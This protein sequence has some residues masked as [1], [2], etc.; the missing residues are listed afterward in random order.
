MYQDLNTSDNFEIF[1]TDND[2]AIYSITIT[3]DHELTN[4]V[5]SDTLGNFDTQTLLAGNHDLIIYKDEVYL[6]KKPD[7]SS[8]TETHN[9]IYRIY[10]NPTNGFFTIQGKNIQSVEII[11]ISGQ[12]IKNFQILNS[13]FR[14]DLSEHPK[15]IYLIKIVTDKGISVE[16]VAIK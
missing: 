1:W 3:S 15:G 14:V 8:V 2:S 11:N 13:K 16:K 6:L 10:P 5:P 4:M 12:V 9:N 7:I